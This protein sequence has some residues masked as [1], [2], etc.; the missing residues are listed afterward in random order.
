MTAVYLLESAVA[1]L[2]VGVLGFLV[3]QWAMN[4][5]RRRSAL[6][7]SLLLLAGTLVLVAHLW[8]KASGT[9]DG[10]AWL[11]LAVMGMGLLFA[12]LSAFAGTW[13]TCLMVSQERAPDAR[14]PAAEL[15]AFARIGVATLVGCWAVYG[16]A[17]RSGDGNPFTPVFLWLTY[18]LTG[19]G[20]VSVVILV[21]RNVALVIRD[22]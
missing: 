1:G 9:A 2:L 7:V 4:G 19:L 17:S 21:A 5:P 13:A 6:L 16:L 11:V 15:A 10:L 20:A 8:P 3:V 12:L 22:A 14:T 18:E